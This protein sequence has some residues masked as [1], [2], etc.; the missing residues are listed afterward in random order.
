MS[1]SL[2][3]HVLIFATRLYSKIDWDA[4]ALKTLTDARAA[5]AA[6]AAVGASGAG[7]GDVAAVFTASEPTPQAIPSA[8]TPSGQPA[9]LRSS[10]TGASAAGLPVPTDEQL[11]LLEPPRV[12]A[13]ANI[14]ATNHDRQA[15]SVEVTG[16][17]TA[18]NSGTPH[19]MPTAGRG[20]V[21]R[22]ARP[23]I[24]STE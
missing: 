14:A 4:L 3:R 13:K 18:S 11:A 9:L 7:T 6:A 17:S 2:P 1:V 16:G 20:R 15:A 23:G 5:E 21:K 22:G 24:P 19:T 8:V 10:S 12:G